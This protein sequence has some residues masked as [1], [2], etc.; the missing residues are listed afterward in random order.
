MSHYGVAT[1]N[2]LW[3]SPDSES[4]NLSAYKLRVGD[5]VHAFLSL[6]VFAV[7]ALL[8]SNTVDCFYPSFESTE[9]LLLMVLPPVIGAI[10]S[11]VF[12]MFP[13]KRHGIGYP[14]SET[15]QES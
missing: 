9:K 12:M 14:S 10:S 5:F 13:N 6:I 4:V 7:V 15:Q 1:K 3:P 2:G 11:T 8:D